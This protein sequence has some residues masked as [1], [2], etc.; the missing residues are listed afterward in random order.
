M[1]EHI[2]QSGAVPR[3]PHYKK[4]RRIFPAP[5][6][7]ATR[8]ARDPGKADGGGE[9]R[10]ARSRPAPPREAARLRAP[11]PPPGPAAGGGRPE[12][13]PHAV[14]GAAGCLVPPRPA[15]PRGRSPGAP[16]RSGCRTWPGGGC[17]S[18]GGGARPTCARRL[19]R[20]GGGGAGS[21]SCPPGAPALAHSSR[22][23]VGPP[24][25]VGTSPARR[26]HGRSAARPPAPPHHA[27]GMDPGGGCTAPLG[28]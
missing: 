25:L 24:G 4:A 12:G 11:R 10:G 21:S 7:G 2:C 18:A 27:A 23:A 26:T 17:P 20:S 19:L 5:A 3:P 15:P 28:C 22:T 8:R 14:P 9:A 13:A 16:L 6:R 1:G